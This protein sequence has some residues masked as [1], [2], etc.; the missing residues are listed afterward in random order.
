MKLYYSPGACSLAS[1]IVLREVSED[2]ELERID[3]NTL[4][5]ESGEDFA[6]INP[7]GYVPA[8]RL[9]EE[10]VLTEGA[11]ILQFIADHHPQAK[12]APTCGHIRRARMN[13]HLNYIAS[14]LHKAFGPLFS[15]TASEESQESPQKTR[16][17]ETG[18]V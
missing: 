7:K 18:T 4:K 9:D 10:Q 2:F 16:C 6:Q 14:E 13:E 5:S 15:E 12:L 3:L 11:A 17:Q 8:L 1:H